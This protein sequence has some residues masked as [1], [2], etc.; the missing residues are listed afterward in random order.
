[1]KLLI[2][3]APSDRWWRQ[4]QQGPT[5]LADQIALGRDVIGD[6]AGEGRRTVYG[7]AFHANRF[8]WCSA[9]YVDEI[10]FESWNFEGLNFWS[11]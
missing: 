4:C 3:D 7:H 6:G 1:M 11:N 5:H 10:E 8:K 2:C 9:A